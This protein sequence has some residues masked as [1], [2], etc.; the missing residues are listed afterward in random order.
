MDIRKQLK[1][2]IFI[3]PNHFCFNNMPE[4]HSLGHTGV[5]PYSW[6]SEELDLTQIDMDIQKQLEIT[7]FIKPKI[8]V[9]TKLSKSHSPEHPGVNVLLLVVPR[10]WTSHRWTSVMDVQKQH[11]ITILIIPNN[12]CFNQIAKK[13]FPGT[14]RGQCPTPGCPRLWTWP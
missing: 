2:T 14:P 7:I 10:L 11:E 6:V 3:I 5:R 4:S 13:S 1:I 9:S 8:F 12:L